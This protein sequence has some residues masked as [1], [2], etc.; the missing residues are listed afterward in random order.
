MARRADPL[1][2]NRRTV[3]LLAVAVLAAACS[4]T[5]PDRATTG[6]GPIVAAEDPTGTTTSTSVESVDQPD[7]PVGPIA[8]PIRHPS[9]H[10]PIYFV[11]PDRFANG[12]PSNDTAGIDGGPLDHGFDPTRKGFHHGGDLAGL[13]GKLDYIADM[14]FGAIWI[15]PPFTNRYVQGNGTLDG[16]SSSYHGY[17]QVDF[18]TI[19]PHLGT[20]D[21]MHDFIAAAHNRDIH[22]YFDIV[23]NHTGDV[24][25]YA[26]QDYA[27]WAQS[28]RPYLDADG[29]EFDPADFAGRDTFPELDPATSF[30]HEPV[31][32]SPEL[33]TIKAP[34]WLN[35]VRL[36]HNR[37]D[38]TFNGESNTYGDF[39]GLDDLFTEHPLVVDGMIELYGDVIETWDIDGF[40]IDTMKHVNHE[41]WAAF[42]PAMTAKASELGKDDFIM[43]GEVFG[44]DPILQSSFTNLGVPATLD[45]ITS[46]AI[47]I[48]LAGGAGT[49]L[50]EGFDDDDWFTD[51]DNNAS[52]QVTFFGNHDE[53]RMGHLIDRSSPNASDDELLAKARMGLDLLWFTRG[54]PVLYY[55]DE[56]GFTGDGG[57][58]LARHDM[59][60]SQ[61][62]EYLDDDLIGT[63][64]TAADD[65]FDTGH[66]LYRHVTALSAFRAEHAAALVDGAQI[67]HP[68][69]SP[70]FAM[71]RLHRDERIEYLVFTNSNPVLTVPARINPLTSTGTFTSLWGPEMTVLVDDGGE[72]V[73]EVPPLTTVMLVADAPVAPSDDA[74]TIRLAR[75]ADDATI[76][77]VRYR[78][79]AEVDADRYAEVTFA[80]A[81]DGGEPQ[82]VGVDDAP[83]YRVYWPN[84]DIP[85]NATI[86]VL[87]TV[88]DGTGR[89]SVDSAFATLG[90]R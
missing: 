70:V 42:A 27:Y 38:S 5:T 2:S 64:A 51:L 57:D 82:I 20:N 11:M 26:D 24:I 1:G 6:S 35:D 72:V 8:A 32:A 16:S 13:T 80:V 61:T 85:D 41:F 62:P 22:V 84:A 48:H 49:V 60:A 39:F 71:S 74:P 53:G 73:V 34:D 77:T 76:P 36:Y 12:D 81:V 83:P 50:T 52:M 9:S 55:G 75:P 89:T 4:S 14:G 10:R 19:D 67:G 33:A 21:E 29:N 37:G 40:R 58:Q 65:N 63:D 66:P 59:F 28:A 90:E 43:F 15:T 7:E 56:Q 54:A 3:A 17:W 47:D 87:A 25:S 30:A 23:V 86:E 68:L 79:E 88:A 45:F 31:F 69:D 44:T 18:T 46:S 78:F